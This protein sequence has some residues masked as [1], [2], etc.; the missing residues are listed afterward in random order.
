MRDKL[1]LIKNLLHGHIL[2]L[3]VVLVITFG[4]IPITVYLVQQQQNL[5][6]KAAGGVEVG[7]LKLNLGE[8]VPKYHSS[9]S[10]NFGIGFAPNQKI[11]GADVTITYSDNLR[12]DTFQEEKAD[13]NRL[14]PIWYGFNTSAGTLRYVAVNDTYT[15]NALSYVPLGRLTF[16]V[17]GTGT[18]I[19]SITDKQIV[20][21]D[22]SGILNVGDAR[23]IYTIEARTPT[24]TPTPT[25]R[26]CSC[27]NGYC[28]PAGLCVNGVGGDRCQGYTE[29]RPVIPTLTPTN[30]PI[31]S[32]TPTPPSCSPSGGDCP[33]PNNCCSGLICQIPPLGLVGSCVTTTATLTP[34]STSTSTP[35][36]TITLTP[37]PTAVPVVYTTD[38]RCSDVSFD[39]DDAG[40]SAPQWKP[41]QNADFSG[42]PINIQYTFTRNII[43][44]GDLT[45]FCQ[46]KDNKNVTSPVTSK[47]I[48][49]IGG[50]PKITSALCTYSPI[51]TGTQIT[52][53][54]R[55]FGDH[56]DQ[57]T[58]NI[59]VEGKD[60]RISY[61]AKDVTD[62]RTSTSSATPTPSN[63]DIRYK[64]I[65]SISDKLSDGKHPI[66]LITD[67]GKVVNGYCSLGLTTVDFTLKTT[68]LARSVDLSANDVAVE[69]KEDIDNAKS[70]IKKIINIDKDGKPVDFN[71]ALEI[72]KTYILSLRAPKTVSRK[73]KFVAEEGTTN[74][75]DVILPVGDIYPISSPDNKVNAFDKGEMSRE[76]SLVADVT[77][78]ADL[79]NDSRVNSV[80]YSCLQSNYNKSGD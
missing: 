1:I 60:A 18:A 74:L 79:N 67:A 58:A 59:K 49:Y 73:V 80:D 3:I 54:G 6:S 11:T 34:T 62:D 43:P 31:L 61:W 55:N 44:G 38:Y 53:K 25:P 66:V 63:N 37:T 30:T 75:N 23:V 77:R 20:A 15:A 8:V 41:Y 45:L 69:I 5:R 27:V 16:F 19:I 51:G 14:T 46:F 13:P 39:K 52:I 10:L 72:D 68:C 28:S 7:T 76:W 12:L 4:I 9:F 32:P 78:V 57:G 47:S 35:T 29:C 65:S 64:V 71:P 17:I 42:V 24:L 2:A 50:E 33:V 22:E 48:K 36:I 21:Q 26:P 70:L 40:S 56:S